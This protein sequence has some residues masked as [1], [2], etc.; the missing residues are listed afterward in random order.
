MEKTAHS[1]A[2][3][4][5]KA[6]SDTHLHGF[7]GFWEVAVQMLLLKHLSQ[8]PQLLE[9]LTPS[10]ALPGVALWSLQQWAWFLVAQDEPRNIVDRAQSMLEELQHPEVVNVKEGCKVDRYMTLF[11]LS[12][13]LCSPE[14]SIL[15]PK[16]GDMHQDMSK[17]LHDY[18][19]AS[20][21]HTYE[22]SLTDGNGP[23]P[24]ASVDMDQ[25]H[26]SSSMMRSN[27]LMNTSDVTALEQL[28]KVLGSGGRCVLELISRVCFAM[29][30]EEEKS[31]LDKFSKTSP[32]VESCFPVLLV[33]NVT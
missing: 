19:I 2:E 27:A 7:D 26:T 16:R 31:S 5:L 33:L 10:P 18:W 11:G 17:P 20:V 3:A 14:N 21:H 24:D 29:P 9:K 12:R 25:S 22:E 23:Q 1:Q 32:A 28:E 15:N 30:K 13:Y 4:L 8:E 6:D